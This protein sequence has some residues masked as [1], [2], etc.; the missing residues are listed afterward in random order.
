MLIRF[1]FAV[2]LAWGSFALRAAE[3]NEAGWK[4]LFD[5][6][7][8]QGW[9]ASEHPDSFKVEDGIIV[10]HGERAHLF[11]TG[12]VEGASFRNFEFVAEVKAAAGA[13]SGVYFHTRY[14]ETGFPQK[15][16]EAQVCNS[17]PQGGA[18]QERKLTGSLYGLRNVYRQIVPDDT[19][20][21]YRITVRGKRV[22][23]RVN[24]LLL[25]DYV[26]PADP[27][28]PP[29]R[30]QRRL[31]R[32]TFA[33][34][35]HDPGSLVR[36]RNLRVKPLPDDADTGAPLPEVDET[37]RQ[38]I[39]LGSG[40]FPLVDFH[41]HLKG[42]LTLDEVLAHMRATGLNHGIAV[43][44]G[45]GFGV[46]NDAGIGAFLKSVAGA[47]V[48]VG[49]QAEGREWPTLFSPA[50]VARFDYVFTDGM[51]IVDHR[52][53]RARLWMKDEVDIPEPQAFMDHLVNTI[54]GILDK[55]PV[56]I[57]VNPTFLPDVIAGDY[58]AL[59]TPARKQRVIDAAA[60]NGVAIEINARYKLPKADFIKA[61]RK[62]GVKFTLG[63][64]NGDR[65][66]GRDEYGLRMIRECGL[67]WQ[68][69]WLPKPD[70]QKPIQV[71]PKR[72]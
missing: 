38:I 41:T 17:P 33:L 40:N 36:F 65:D 63:T 45:V 54:V 58:D 44:C 70:G 48:F 12:E 50:A 72:L 25:V 27:V 46:T 29:Q 20:F 11:Y 39:D 61:A 4:S 64:N 56:D 15:G 10:V 55:E 69:F 66:L 42:G 37:F 31:D 26:E 67:T 18:Y 22:Q 19:W 13:N 9:K 28:L 43:N 62:A 53:K 23:I 5:G 16:F 57:Y 1:V 30:P 49:M 2:G 68:D 52:G 60:R 32:G 71:R 3:P 7:T 35:G 34:Q 8:L 59:W 21:T 24:D 51:T 14:Q 47:P 6:Q